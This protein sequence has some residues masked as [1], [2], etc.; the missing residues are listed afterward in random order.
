MLP[1]LGGSFL[2]CFL[3]VQESDTFLMQKDASFQSI[4]T[5]AGF[6]LLHIPDNYKGMKSIINRYSGCGQLNEILACMLFL[7]V[8]SPAPF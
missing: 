3:F 1:V 2:V 4:V 6:P 8:F 7:A 5:L